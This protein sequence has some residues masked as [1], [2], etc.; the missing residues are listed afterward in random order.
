MRSDKFTAAGIPPGSGWQKD[1]PSKLWTNYHS[2]QCPPFLS[3]RIWLEGQVID[4]SCQSV[5]RFISSTPLDA[6]F[7]VVRVRL[8]LLAAL[9]EEPHWSWI[10]FCSPKTAEPPLPLKSLCQKTSNLQD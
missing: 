4:D 5:V 10:A 7:A 1:I 8:R 3:S 6:T 2:S 9:T